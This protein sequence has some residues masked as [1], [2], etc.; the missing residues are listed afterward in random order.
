METIVG[1]ALI[2]ISG[3]LIYGIIRVVGQNAAS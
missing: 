2:V 1:L 3:I